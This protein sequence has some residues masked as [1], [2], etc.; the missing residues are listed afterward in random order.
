MLRVSLQNED[1][2][3]QYVTYITSTAYSYVLPE[4]L[5]ERCPIGKSCGVLV[6][7]V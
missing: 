7:F 6:R 2:T 4:L 3:V 1:Y 5:V